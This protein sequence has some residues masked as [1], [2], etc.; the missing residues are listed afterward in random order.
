MAWCAYYISWK[1]SPSWHYFP[2]FSL[3]KQF[4][5]NMHHLAQLSPWII[6]ASPKLSKLDGMK[7][8]NT[9]I[10]TEYHQQ[11]AKCNYAVCGCVMNCGKEFPNPIVQYM[12]LNLIFAGTSLTQFLLTWWHPKTDVKHNFPWHSTVEQVKGLLTSTL[13]I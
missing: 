4:V 12:F 10:W 5:W 1:C 3:F 8:R 9:W 13:K 11:I 2:S 7:L 6:L